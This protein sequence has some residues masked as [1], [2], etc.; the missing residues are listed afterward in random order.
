MG[1]KACGRAC[2]CRF[3]SGRRAIVYARLTD[4]AVMSILPVVASSTATKVW[5]MS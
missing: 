4:R 5:R 2:S 1:W 3:R